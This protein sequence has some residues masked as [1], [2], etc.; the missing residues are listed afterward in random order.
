MCL[1]WLALFMC[2]TGL[3]FAESCHATQGSFHFFPQESNQKKSD[4]TYYK[5]NE[6]SLSDNITELCQVLDTKVKSHTINP[7][8][9]HTKVLGGCG[10]RSVRDAH[11]SGGEGS[12]ATRAPR[13]VR[14]MQQRQSTVAPNVKPCFVSLPRAQAS[15]TSTGGQRKV[16]KFCSSGIVATTSPTP[17][18][19]PFTSKAKHLVFKMASQ[20]RASSQCQSKSTVPRR[21]S[22]TKKKKS[23]TS[24][25]SSRQRRGAKSTAVTGKRK[26]NLNYNHSASSTSWVNSRSSWV[27]F[28]KRY[29][30]VRSPYNKKVA[31]NEKTD[32]YANLLVFNAAP[33]WLRSG[34]IEFVCTT[35]VLRLEVMFW[36]Q[37]AVY[38]FFFYS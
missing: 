31:S 6:G 2:A 28:V 5:Q 22:C 11:G 24:K 23:T 33:H 26:K 15:S 1:V 7:R 18:S 19:A 38:L 12:T 25:V 37:H 21:S 34:G 13:N 10:S 17:L 9:K 36:L 29:P 20:S 8:S 14:V 4:S 16:H 35:V 3:I 32:V 27:V 30:S